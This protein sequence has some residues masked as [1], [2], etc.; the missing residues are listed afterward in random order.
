MTRAGVVLMTRGIHTLAGLIVGKV[1][2]DQFFRKPLAV[3]ATS[4]ST[5]SPSTLLCT[6]HSASMMGRH[7][8]DGNVSHVGAPSIG[9]SLACV[10]SR[11]SGHRGQ[12]S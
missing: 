10:S 9:S 3:V 12:E 8:L 7:R 5:R 2:D 11:A 1:I 4:I 6:Y